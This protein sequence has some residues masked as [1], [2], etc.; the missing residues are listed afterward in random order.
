MKEWHASFEAKLEALERK[1]E[2]EIARW[3]NVQNYPFGIMGWLK[4]GT[5]DYKRIIKKIKYNDIME[6]SL[7]EKSK[8]EVRKIFVQPCNEQ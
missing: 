5:T 7:K 6:S 4:F 1:H 2:A 3:F 8:K